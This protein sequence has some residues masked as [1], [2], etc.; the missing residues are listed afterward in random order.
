MSVRLVNWWFY[1]KKRI[2]RGVVRKCQGGYVDSTSVKLY[3]RCGKIS[4]LMS[5][6]LSAQGIYNTVLSSQ[7]KK[8]I[9]MKPNCLTVAVSVIESYV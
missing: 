3:N 2:F 7:C 1:V 9:F 8:G 6:Q 4:E 5:E